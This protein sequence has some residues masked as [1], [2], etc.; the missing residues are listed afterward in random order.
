MAYT[1]SFFSLN[2]TQNE[3]VKISGSLRFIIYYKMVINANNVKY[4]YFYL[5][6]LILILIYKYNYFMYRVSKDTVEFFVCSKFFHIFL[7]VYLC[8]NFFNFFVW[9]GMKERQGIHMVPFCHF[10]TKL[11][12]IS[13]FLFHKIVRNISSSITASPFFEKGGY[14]WYG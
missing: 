9:R 6:Y 12:T 7:Q 1:R 14:Q 8:S 4:F 3:C 2:L 13:M 5:I 10:F 11:W